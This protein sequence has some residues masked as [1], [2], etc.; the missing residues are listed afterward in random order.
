M[1]SVEKTVFLSYRRANVSWALAV[2]QDLS[3]HGYDVFFDFKQAILE[4]IEA[5]AHFLI[6][7]TPTAL[8]RC[9]EPRDWLRQEIEHALSTRRNIVPLM[10]EGFDFDAVLIRSRLAGHLGMLAQYSGLRVFAEY[11]PAA[12]KDLREKF[13]NVPLDA[14]SCFLR[15]EDRKHSD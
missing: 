15:C 14:A 4:N 9:N 1:G 5:R 8:N 2:F 7:L 12:M 10:L 3:H 13:L 11:F 6:L